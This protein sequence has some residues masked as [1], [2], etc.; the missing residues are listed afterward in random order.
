MVT[1]NNCYY[2]Y[3]PLIEHPKIKFNTTLSVFNM[4]NTQVQLWTKT[5]LFT[6]EF[7]HSSITSSFKEHNTNLSVC[8][9]YSI[10]T[11]KNFMPIILQV[12][13]TS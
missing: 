8:S 11:S 7:T 3:F 6:R 1:A 4:H 2:H 5:I 10:G 12:H 13:V 9:K